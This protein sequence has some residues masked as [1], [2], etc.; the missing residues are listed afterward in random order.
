M[1]H[2]YDWLFQDALLLVQFC[3][4]TFILSHTFQYFEYICCS[5]LCVWLFLLRFPMFSFRMS[6]S[7]CVRSSCVLPL[8]IIFAFYVQFL[9]V[10]RPLIHQYKFSWV[11]RIDY[12]VRMLFFFCIWFFFS[13]RVCVCVCE[14]TLWESSSF[15]SL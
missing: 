4:T 8:F 10:V 3:I 1:M 11:L 12:F 13:C 15:K 6:H 2:S 9:L 14:S 7:L 5:S